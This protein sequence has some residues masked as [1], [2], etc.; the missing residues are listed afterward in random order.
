MN[1]N[2]HINN[3]QSY[4]VIRK[5]TIMSKS[6]C[7]KIA[8]CKTFHQ[9]IY[10]LQLRTRTKAY[11]NQRLFGQD[12]KREVVLQAPCFNWVGYFECS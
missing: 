12:L 4:K 8:K 6:K 2:K 5:I 10:I 1:L 11:E 7:H 9:A 3:H